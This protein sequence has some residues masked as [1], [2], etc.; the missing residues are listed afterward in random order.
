MQGYMQ[1]KKIL[2][3]NT[4][5]I[6]NALDQG[7][8]QEINHLLSDNFSYDLYKSYKNIGLYNFYQGIFDRT[9]SIP[10]YINCANYSKLFPI[11]KNDSKIM[12]FSEIS[13][14]VAQKII[15]LGKPINVFWSGGLDSTYVLMSLLN[16]NVKIN[17]ICDYNSILESGNVYERFLKGRVNLDIRISTSREK[18]FENSKFSDQIFVTGSM[19]NQM[20]RHSPAFHNYG[21]HASLG[22]KEQAFEKYENIIETKVIDFFKP[23]IDVFPLKIKTLGDF[24]FM[25]NYAFTWANPYHDLYRKMQVDDIKKIIHFFDDIEFEKWALYNEEYDPEEMLNNDRKPLRDVLYNSG[26]KEYSQLKKKHTSVISIEPNDK[27][28]WVCMFDDYTNLYVRKY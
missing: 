18:I 5:F 8:D 22:K 26:L 21:F 23:A 28:E 9:G 2:T 7:K 15:N 3:Y 14:K 17:V 25:L 19:S 11:P 16:F 4:F 20:F 10:H 13:N 12:A 1:N 24:K 6:E 27:M